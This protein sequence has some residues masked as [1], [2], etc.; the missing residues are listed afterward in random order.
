MNALETAGLVA[1]HRSKGGGSDRTSFSLTRN[2]MAALYDA[3]LAE[4][5]SRA[6][7]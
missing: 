3:S 6:R 2:G 1:T 5:V 7:D 4:A